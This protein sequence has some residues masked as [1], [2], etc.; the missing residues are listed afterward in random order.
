LPCFA[1]NGT[2]LDYDG[3]RIREKEIIK[4]QDV[5]QFLNQFFQMQRFMKLGIGGRLLRNLMGIFR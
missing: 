4:P 5:K 1:G 2:S 3:R